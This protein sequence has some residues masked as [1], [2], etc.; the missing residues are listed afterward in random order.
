MK[1]KIIDWMDDKAMKVAANMKWNALKIGDEI[2]IIDFVD[3]EKQEGEMKY[4]M[5][6]DSMNEKNRTVTGPITTVGCGEE[7]FPE[8]G[9]VTVTG[10]W[11]LVHYP[12]G[13]SNS[14]IWMKEV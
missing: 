1:N 14:E 10:E 7:Y 13:F 12:G 6:I 8:D 5:R 4:W 2:K 9:I 11:Y 3:N